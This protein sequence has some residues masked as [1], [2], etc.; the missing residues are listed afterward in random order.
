VDR[1]PN[2]V[3]CEWI[4]E[5]VPGYTVNIIFDERFDVEVSANCSN[6][7]LEVIRMTHHDKE[8]NKKRPLILFVY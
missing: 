1:Y 4:I 8:T 2:S 6:D 3:E 7:Y 5:T